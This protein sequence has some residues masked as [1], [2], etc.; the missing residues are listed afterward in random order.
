MNKISIEISLYSLQNEYRKAVLDFL[1]DLESTHQV[2]IRY[3]AMSTLVIGDYELIMNLIVKKIK[4]IFEN[5]K[6]VFVLKISNAC[7]PD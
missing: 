3:S 2:E 1:K 7:L 4:L 6:A 5:Y